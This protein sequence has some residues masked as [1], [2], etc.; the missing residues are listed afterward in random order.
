MKQGYCGADNRGIKCPICDGHDSY[1]YRSI[2]HNGDV[3]RERICKCENR[4]FTSEK[5]IDCN[6][7]DIVAKGRSYAPVCVEGEV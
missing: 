6:I 1:V 3:L 4:Y 2:K 5:V 7:Y